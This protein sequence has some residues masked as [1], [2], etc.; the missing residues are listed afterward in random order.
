MTAI[1]SFGIEQTDGN[2]GTLPDASVHAKIG[3]CS[4]GSTTPT[5]VGSRAALADFGTG[6]LVDATAYQLEVTGKPVL[7]CRSTASVAGIVGSLTRFGAGAAA[8]AITLQ[9]GGTST[10]APALVAVGLSRAYAVRIRVT[11]A[12]TDLADDPEIQYSLD[13]GLTWSAAAVA[14]SGAALGASGITLNWTDGTFVGAEVWTGYATPST[15]T[16]AALPAISG[17][18]FDGYRVAIK[19]SRAAPNLAANTAA[20]QVSLDDGETYGPELAVPGTGIVALAGTGLLATFSNSSF[21]VGDRY[22]FRTAAP[23][24]NLSD[25]AA[26][27]ERMLASSSDVELVHVVGPADAT[28][29]TALDLLAAGALTDH[30]PRIILL[31]ARAARA[32]ETAAAWRADIKDDFDGFESD[33]IAV[34]A[35]EADYYA[36]LGKRYVRRSIGTLV[37]AR[38]SLVP[39]SEDLA[40]VARGNL[41]GVLSIT[42]DED[43]SPDLNAARF[44]TTRQHQGLPGY[45]ITNPLLMA[46]PGSDFALLQRRRVWDRAYRVLRR[47]VLPF[48]SA[49]LNVNPAGVDAPLTAG[50]IDEIDAGTIEDRATD[51]L[52][53]ALIKST[54]QHVSG[55]SVTVDRSNNILTTEELIVDFSIVP[56]AY[57]KTIRGR[58]GFTNPARA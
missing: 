41:P 49:D 28:A 30:K 54:P 17:T 48:L 4:A 11:T 36:V 52:S 20:V 8:A 31:E 42:H 25:I 22:E 16:G 12:G 3:V 29:A 27:F 15:I 57:A 23:A 46:A 6:P 10:A 14:V 21:V 5:M 24:P 38:A 47:V 53:D 58:L 18:P 13:G 45:Y 43:S 9:G 56:K 50:G 40:F 37:A 35:G 44:I 32:D 39:I 2:I 55:V 1:P 33:R 34:C 26:A 51:A 19:V 7:V